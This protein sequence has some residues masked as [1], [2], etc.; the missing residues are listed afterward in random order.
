MEK[1]VERESEWK[2]NAVLYLVYFIWLFS[3]LHGTL[4]TVTLLVLNQ[5]TPPPTLFTPLPHKTSGHAMSVTSM[6]HHNL[7]SLTTFL[8]ALCF[9]LTHNGY[10]SHT[11]SMFIWGKEN[12]KSLCKWKYYI[13]IKMTVRFGYQ[14]THSIC[15]KYCEYFSKDSILRTV[16]IQFVEKTALEC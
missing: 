7:D 13:F 3:L 10:N 14:S 4:P 1:R 11:V 5:T 16:Q 2:Q 9:Y 15:F 12:L 6:S 8:L